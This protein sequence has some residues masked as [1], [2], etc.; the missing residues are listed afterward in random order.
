MEN[1]PA[2]ETVNARAYT[3]PTEDQPESDGTL[4]WDSTTMVLVEAQAGGETGL[5]YAYTHTAAAKL[6]EGKLAG[7]V[8]GRGSLSVRS[9]WRAMIQAIRNL[10]RPGLV[11]SAVAAVDTALWDLKARLLGQPLTV[12]LDAVHEKAPIYGS[13]GFTSYSIER[14]QQQLAG[15]VEQGIP[16][17]KMKVGR[18]PETDLARVAAAREAIGEETEL[19][20]DAN[21]AYTQ[22]QALRFAHLFSEEHGVTWLEEPVSSDDL[23]GLRLVREEGPPGLEITAGEYG[24]TAFYFRHMLEAGAVDCLQAD[25]TRCGG[26]TGFLDV[27]ALC[28]AHSMDLSAHTAPNLHAHALCAVQRARHIEHFHDHARIEQMFFEG[29][30]TPEGGFLEPDRSRPGHG[31]VFKAQDAEDYQVYGAES[32]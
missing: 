20:V 7:I 19:M 27:A 22:K 24:Y 26:I 17:V 16:R 1:T 29:A 4:R 18:Q 15:W 28:R 11:S 8:E 10:G 21:G 23:E 31:L 30:L 25:A 14:L 12:A 5:G 32:S 2:I 6:I 3:V 13:G 9:A